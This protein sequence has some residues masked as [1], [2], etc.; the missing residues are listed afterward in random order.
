MN[1]VPVILSG[2]TGS[3][4]WPASRQQTPKQLLPLVDHRT[5]L[6]T[7]LERAAAVPG[8]GDPI[9]V[10]NA[11]QRGAIEAELD[12]VGWTGTRVILEPVGR[13]TAPALAVAALD[14][15]DDPLLL[16]LPADHVIADEAEF[17]AAVGVGARLAEQGYLVTFGIMPTRP[18]TGY[19]YIEVG[20]A[21]GE[22]ANAVARF[23]EKPDAETAERYLTDGRHLWN[24]GMFLFAAGRYLEELEQHRPDVLD[25][26]RSALARAK[27]D[28]TAVIL[29]ADSME[30]APSV[31]IDYAVM[32]PT[33][34]AA[35]VPL[36]AGWT[37]VGSWKALWAIGATDDDGNVVDGDVELIDVRNSLVRSHGR[38]IA[39]IGLEGVVVVDTPDAT[40]VSSIDRVQDVK[41]L[42]DR[43]TELGRTEVER[44]DR[45][46]GS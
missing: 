28:G 13:N 12:A 5:M 6:L 27:D 22:G 34:R 19:G 25:A 39:V 11:D 42:V 3:R 44:I 1:V 35:V 9:I 20:E 43:L 38:L 2:G 7:T 30:R 32:E 45:D 16:V 15:H 24:S 41:A 40:L 17:V 21:L 29:D 18:E 33:T 46:G 23:K 31:S 36:D 37:D 10:A 26:A 14:T 4:L 8:A